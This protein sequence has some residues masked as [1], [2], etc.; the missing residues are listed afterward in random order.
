[1]ILANLA[2]LS[3]AATAA[4]FFPRRVDPGTRRS[5]YWWRYKIMHTMPQ[6]CVEPQ[7]SSETVR[8][9]KLATEVE[10]RYEL[11]VVHGGEIESERASALRLADC[12]RKMI[13]DTECYMNSRDGKA[14]ARL[15]HAG[16]G[17]A[18]RLWQEL[19]ATSVDVRIRRRG[20]VPNHFSPL[21]RFGESPFD[22]MLE[23]HA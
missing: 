19:L 10:P 16:P 22:S 13:R 7:A 3:P 2:D 9:V 8:R 20:S 6:I 4:S 14:W 23:A 17:L 21:C 5:T 18:A 1:M 11:R 15:S 12:R